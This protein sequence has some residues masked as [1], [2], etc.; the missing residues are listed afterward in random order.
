MSST[1]DVGFRALRA[2]GAGLTEVLATFAVETEEQVIPAASHEL[3]QAALID[4]VG[5]IV[6]GGTTDTFS[7]LTAAF[8]DETGAGT[9]TILPTQER[10]SPRVAALLNATAGHALDYD[11]ATYASYGHPSVVLIP[12]L[13]AVAES[14]GLSGPA[15][16]TAYAVGLSCL[17]S[18]ADGIDIT[19]HYAKGWHATATVGVIGATAAVSRLMS[20]S[21]D[22]TRN[23]LGIAGSLAAGSRRNF[24]T[25]TKPLHAG[26]AA[27]NAV[28]AATLAGT[29]F[30]AD[31][32]ILEGEGGYLWLF[33]HPEADPGRAVSAIEDRPWAF[34]EDV[35]HVK[36][37]PC[38]F[39]LHRAVT[40]ARRLALRHSV[41]PEQIRSID[42]RVEAGGL[43]PLIERLPATGLEAKFSMQYTVSSVIT[44]GSLQLEAFT[45]QAVKRQSVLEL[46]SR[47]STRDGERRRVEERPFAEVEITL[48]DGRVLRD[49]DELSPRSGLSVS[50]KDLLAK[51]T[52]CLAL[53]QPGWD[54]HLLL[55]RLESML[56][57]SRVG[58]GP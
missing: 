24:G 33:G 51:F 34:L 11:D 21:V 19:A 1:A 10:A 12:A 7:A 48:T 22:Q 6:A 57:N 56:L 28:F 42:V 8:A 49:R 27:S 9:A 31:P 23:A 26:V 47:V 39:N 15:V 29:G 38:C 40:A 17:Y 18:L 44:D 58:F 45:D 35:P 53:A 2:R 30:T 54:R 41:Q 37:Y 46:A 20:L 4:T 50:R 25:M 14:G 13:L 32:E 55:Q 43:A 52:D 5:V 36:L 16:A 3:A